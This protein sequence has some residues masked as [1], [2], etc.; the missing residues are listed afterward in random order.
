[1]GLYVYA[2]PVPPLNVSSISPAIAAALTDISPAEIIVGPGPYQ[3]AL[4]MR[5]KLFAM[6]EYTTTSATPTCVL[7]FYMNAVGTAIGTTEAILAA[8]PANA[9]GASATAAPWQAWWN[10]RVTAIS[11]PADAANATVYG[12]G[13]VKWS[14]NAGGGTNAW[15]SVN[16]IP[17]TAALKTVAQTATGLSTLNNQKIMIGST[18]ST[19]T[20][21]TSMT[22]D[23]FTCELF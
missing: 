2:S 11:G 17:L 15:T 23:E 10:G 19:V 4:G 20:G 16:P 6:G 14:V 18:W 3:L 21:V 8:G 22:C 1:M 5:I 7:G 12:Q 13:E 9:A